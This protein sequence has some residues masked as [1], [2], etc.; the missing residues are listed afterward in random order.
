M[1]FMR[2]SIWFDVD[3]LP[4][5]VRLFSAGLNPCA[6]ET[7]TPR[8]RRFRY[9]HTET[10]L[11]GDG[12]RFSS[13]PSIHSLYRVGLTLRFTTLPKTVRPS[14]TRRILDRILLGISD[15]GHVAKGAFGGV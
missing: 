10:S 7:L 13:G 12:I 11:H 5:Q 3:L 6:V 9:A 8:S 4:R 14:S 2:S 15:D 1:C